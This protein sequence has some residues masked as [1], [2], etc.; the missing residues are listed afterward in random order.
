MNMVPERTLREIL[1][2]EAQSV[3]VPPEMWGQIKARLQQPGPAV[4][5]LPVAANSPAWAGE[6]PAETEAAPAGRKTHRSRTVA[7]VWRVTGVAAVAAALAMLPAIGVHQARQLPQAA[8]DQES[9]A[10]PVFFNPARSPGAMSQ[11][12]AVTGQLG[13]VVFR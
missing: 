6:E 2:E 10:V 9:V 5:P 13:S 4:L 11:N 8:F 12:S 3:A 7:V 1:E